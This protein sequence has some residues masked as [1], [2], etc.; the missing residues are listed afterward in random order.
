MWKLE[1]MFVLIIGLS[2]F[3]LAGHRKSHRISVFWYIYLRLV[4]LNGKLV[5]KYAIRTIHESYGIEQILSVSVLFISRDLQERSGAWKE[6]TRRCATELTLQAAE[7]DFLQ[8]RW[9]RRGRQWRLPTLL[10]GEID[11]SCRPHAREFGPQIRTWQQSR[12]AGERC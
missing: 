7:G 10:D 12:H 4:D 5:R 2:H 11:D 1:N 9:P 3:L 6:L 8:T